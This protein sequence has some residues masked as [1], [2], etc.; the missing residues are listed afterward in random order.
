[1]LAKYRC[2]HA[3]TEFNV[4]G[5]QD[6]GCTVEG[7]GPMG[8]RDTKDVRECEFLRSFLRT[9]KKDVGCPVTKF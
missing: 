9:P 1:M 8:P 2:M 7:P 6:H 3:C 5:A 4:G